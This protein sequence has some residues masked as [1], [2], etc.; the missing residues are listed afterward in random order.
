MLT[1]FNEGQL[2]PRSRQI[3]T[4][5][6]VGCERCYFAIAESIRM[7]ASVDRISRASSARWI[8]LGGLAA[9]LILAT[10]TVTWW[11]TRNN[12][13]AIPTRGGGSVIASDAR[14]SNNQVRQESGPVADE[15]APTRQSAQQ[16]TTTEQA[17]LGDQSSASAS[18]EQVQRLIALAKMQIRPEPENRL[19]PVRL[20]WQAR[21]YLVRWAETRQTDDALAALDAAKHA[22]ATDPVNARF[23]A[24]VALEAAS[25]SMRIDAKKLWEEYLTFDSNSPRAREI[26]RHL[27]LSRESKDTVQ[28]AGSSAIEPLEGK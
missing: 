18:V 9:C 19:N 20:N 1:A 17:K 25:T 7:D 4:A 28:M 2:D 11:I 3:V 5:H 23:N 22:S 27:S 16:T 24:A 8:G 13:A 14:G 12:V 10:N 6:L 15:P 21:D 26:K